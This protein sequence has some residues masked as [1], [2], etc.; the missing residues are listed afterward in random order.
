MSLAAYHKKRDFS[1]TAEPKGVKNDTGALRFVVQKHQATR[2]HYDF[3]LELSGVLVSWAVPKGPSMDPSEKRLAVHVEDHPVSYIDFKGTIPKGNYGAGKVEIWDKGKFVP[4]D[5]SHRPITEK[6]AL[7]SIRKGE[8][9]VAL[10]GKKLK[11]EFV[12]VRLKDEAKNWLLIKHKDEFSG[13]TKPSD[14]PITSLRNGKAKKIASFIKPM[15]AELHKTP[16]DDPEWL[17]EIKWDG[18]R[19]IAVLGETKQL[20][21]RNGIDFSTRFPAV[22]AALDKVRHNCILDGEIVL[23]NEHNLPDFQKLQHYEMH[24]QFPLV[25]YVFDLLELDGTDTR[26]LPLKDRKKLLKKLLPKD[27]LIRYC[28]HVEADGI[29]FL[30]KTKEMGLEGVIAKKKDS[31]YQSGV[32]GKD[33]LKLKHV[34]SSEAV[35]VGYTSPKG[36]RKGFGSLVLATK[37]RQKV[38]GGRW[39]FRGHVGT[40]FSEKGLADLMKT[41][42]TYET[43][44]MPFDKKPLLNGK[45]TWLKPFLVA[46]IAYTQVTRDGIFR[47][48]VFIRLRDDKEVDAVNDETQAVDGGVIKA[49]KF[50]VSV[51]NLQKVYFP[52]EGITKGEVIAYYEKIAP[53]ILPYLKSRTLSLNR[54]PNGIAS[55]SFYQKDAGEHVPSFVKTDQIQSGEEKTIDYIVC[56]NLATLLYVANLGS[57]EMNP[58]NNLISYPEHPDWMVIDLDPSDKNSF[59]QV[60]EVALATKDVLD[61]AGVSSYCKTSGASGLHV[62]VPLHHR[63]HYDQVKDFALLIARKVQE[64]MPK[65]TT[66]ERS[67]KKRGPQIYL[68]YLQNR[69]GQT[70]ASVYSLRP[71]NGA[72]VS[73]PLEWKELNGKL[74]PSAFTM[75]TIFERLRKKGDLFA[76]LLKENIDLLTAL[77]RLE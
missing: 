28:D 21:S 51:T 62:Y 10:K 58:S 15:L 24:Q 4:V 27:K 54:M 55:E 26:K 32:R 8:L 49:G 44:N 73:T 29:A 2:L 60:V 9:K 53:Y 65:I 41:M 17:Y 25:Y 43:E 11:G 52:K 5:A 71:R 64:R 75:H 42:K 33:W 63:Y 36:A 18:Y 45:V 59:S 50:K 68:D 23:L 40:G 19:A 35:I 31:I 7:Q 34:E 20:Y 48:P 13:K 6:Q 76:P 66:L 16:F 22:F 46:D 47:H 74:Q 38:E 1:K 39:K 67:L 70:L 12:L 37:E 72:T 61:Q 3:R 56:N 57:I 14:A 77:R 69:R 30:A